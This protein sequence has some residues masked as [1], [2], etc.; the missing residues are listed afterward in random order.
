[1]K[2]RKLGCPLN[3]IEASF[4]LSIADAVCSIQLRMNIVLT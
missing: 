4:T 2:V 1:M 3:D